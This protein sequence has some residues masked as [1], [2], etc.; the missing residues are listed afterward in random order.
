[1]TP[2]PTFGD[3][4]VAAFADAVAART[5]AP[6]GGATT[7]VAVAMAAG[8]VGMSARF[9]SGRLGEAAALAEAADSIRLRALALADQDAA[10]YR[11]V[12]ADRS[13]EAYE[14]ATAVPIEVAGLAADVAGFA[15]TLLEGGNPAL[16]GDA[17]AGL[18]LARAAC[19]AAADLVAINVQAFS[20]ADRWNAD[21]AACVARAGA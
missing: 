15:S 19:R 21:A 9:S 18:W 10:A 7:A 12:L 5:S 3:L 2:E 13:D 16:A 4:S 6:G 17:G 8:L 11:A 20:L 1:M 14:Q